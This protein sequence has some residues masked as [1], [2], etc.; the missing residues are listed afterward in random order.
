MASTQRPNASV[1]AAVD[2]H[3]RSHGTGLS[4]HARTIAPR[5]LQVANELVKAPSASP[6]H[7]PQRRALQLLD[8]NRLASV[9]D[10]TVK[11]ALKPVGIVKPEP[12]HLSGLKRKH[13][14]ARPKT[15]V[16]SRHEN[17]AWLDMLVALLERKYQAH[18]LPV[19]LQ[20]LEDTQTFGVSRPQEHDE[21]RVKRSRVTTTTDAKPA[22]TRA[23]DTPRGLDAE[24]AA[25]YH[26]MSDAEKDK[27][28][29]RLQTLRRHAQQIQDSSVSSSTCCGC[30]TGCLKMYCV[31]FS[32]RGFCHEGCSCDNCKNARE[33]TEQRVD[34][35]QSYLNNDPR[36]FSFASQQNTSTT[37][38]YQLLPEK[39]STV[40]LRGCR[41]KKSK[42]LKKYCECFQNGLG[43]SPHCRCVDCA[44]DTSK[45]ARQ[46]REKTKA[47]RAVPA[48]VTPFHAIKVS[49]TKKPRR[50]FVQ[51]SIR[52]R[53]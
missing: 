46:L 53:L 25:R 47:E 9:V 29:K 27:E 14:L 34:A 43:C 39:S 7:T 38:F 13:D 48:A 36:A 15:A 52:L 50:N 18:Q 8:S 19:C 32:T 24:A 21:R 41:C 20:D 11:T 17:I 42:C 51:K 10:A 16:S 40:V 33:N 23:V 6:V 37:G 35:I 2:P 44:N 26:K 3:A 49:V 22:N 45:A 28:L 5:A 12:R 31:C 4:M 30:K 1:S